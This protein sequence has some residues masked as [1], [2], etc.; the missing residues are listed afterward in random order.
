VAS[1]RTLSPLMPSRKSTGL[2]RQI[3]RDIAN[4]RRRYRRRPTA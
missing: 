1:T 2:L 3:D 4:R